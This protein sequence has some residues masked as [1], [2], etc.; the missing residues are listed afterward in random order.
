MDEITALSIEN[1]FI[2]E[3]MGSYQLHKYLS[4]KYTEPELHWASAKVFLSIQEKE[5]HSFWSHFYYH[6]YSHYAGGGPL[7]PKEQAVVSFLENRI[8][9]FLW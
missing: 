5:V 2:R 7:P 6:H 1:N 9:G 8:K 3:L 4:P